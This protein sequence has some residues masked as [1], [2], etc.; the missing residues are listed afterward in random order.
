MSEDWLPYFEEMELCSEE[1]FEEDPT[2][3]SS[4]VELI[5][6]VENGKLSYYLLFYNSIRRSVAK[7]FSGRTESYP[8]FKADFKHRV[9]NQDID[10]DSK[11]KIL[12]YCLGKVASLECIRNWPNGSTKVEEAFEFMDKKYSKRI[13]KVIDRYI[14]EHNMVQRYN[15]EDLKSLYSNFM[16]AIEFCKCFNLLD[17]YKYRINEAILK[18]LPLDITNYLLDISENNPLNLD[19]IETILLQEIKLAEQ[20]SN[21]SSSLKQI[22]S[23]SSFDVSTLDNAE[24]ILLDEIQMSNQ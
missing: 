18:K 19:D 20:M 16:K 6:E 5:E 14:C 17:S 2:S 8:K 23:L 22:L 24:D 10:E 12:K 13:N 1:S 11:F 15:L 4:N 21:I 9:W 7:K 3:K